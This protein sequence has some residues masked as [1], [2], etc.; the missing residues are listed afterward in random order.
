M[1]TTINTE[2]KGAFS[3]SIIGANNANNAG[4]GGIANPDGGDLLILRAT[5]YVKTHS[6]GAAN[7]SAGIGA[8]GAAST[9]IVNA[10]AMGGAIDGKYYNGFIMQNGAKTEAAAP[11][12]WTSSTFLNITGSADTT[13]LDAT[14]YL[15]YVRV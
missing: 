7:L 8:A 6:T 2:G 14:L 1:T 12:V 15:E 9:D 13:G 10:L 5:L 4:L 11:A 3:V